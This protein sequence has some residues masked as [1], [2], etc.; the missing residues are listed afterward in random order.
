MGQTDGEFHI[1]KDVAG[2]SDSDPLDSDVVFVGQT[3]GETEIHIKKEFHDFAG[4]SDSDPDL[5]FMG[6]RDGEVLTDGEVRVKEERDVMD[7][8][9]DVC[10]TG[11][12]D[13][14]V[15]VKT[16]ECDSVG[17][18]DWMAS[19]SDDAFRTILCTEMHLPQ[20]VSWENQQVSNLMFQKGNWK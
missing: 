12:T 18:F 13:G 14:D 19:L 10:V 1:K 9:S 16:E 15:H 7:S 11:H 20:L 6:Q 3:D 8:D 4:Q 5:V 2:Q 17:Q